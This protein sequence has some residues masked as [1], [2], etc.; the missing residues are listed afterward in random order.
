MYIIEE[1]QNDDCRISAKIPPSLFYLIL[2]SNSILLDSI[3]KFPVIV[4]FVD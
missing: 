3:L 2:T 4:Y 1:A